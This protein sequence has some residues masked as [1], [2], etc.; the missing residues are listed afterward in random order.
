MP[1]INFKEIAKKINEPWQPLDVVYLND[2]ALRIAKIDGAYN[3]HMH[4]K[5]DEFFLVV[6]G[7]VFIDL[8]NE[9]IQLKENEGFLVKRG[10]KHRSRAEKPAW[11]LLIE[12]TATKSKGDK[13][14]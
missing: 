7:E 2:T 3:W 8:D 12:P 1:K 14:K 10:T 5:E 9:S 13:E 11:V 4:G 6:K